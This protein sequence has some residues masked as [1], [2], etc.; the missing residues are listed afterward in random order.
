MCQATETAA[1]PVLKIQ[2]LGKGAVVLH[3]PWQFHLGDEPSF[4]APD[5]DDATGNDGWEQISADAPWGKQGHWNDSGY[6]WYRI[7]LDITPAS[8]VAPDWSML[9]PQ[10]FDIYSIYWNGRLIVT[11][12]TF[13]PY[14]E[15]TWV[16]NPQTFSLGPLGNGVLAV[17]V[18][19][20]PPGSTDSGFTGGF[21][22][23]P[24]LGGPGAIAT[25]AA[26]YKYVWLR[27]QLFTFATISLQA[28]LMLLALIAWW[29]DRSQHLLLFTACFCFGGIATFADTRL[30]L[31]FNQLLG[32]GIL[33]P[34]YAVRDIGLMYLV[35]WLLDLQRIPSLARWTRV[36]AIANAIFMLADGAV[37]VMDWSNPRLTLFCQWAD[38]LLTVLYSLT[39][40]WPVVLVLFAI[41][42]RLDTPRWM[43]AVFACLA[44]LSFLVP[45]TLQQGSR[46]THWNLGGTLMRPLFT[47]MGNEF[48]AYTLANF[49]LLISIFYAVFAYSR[50]VL[51]RK[52]TIE[53]ELRSAKELMQVLIPEALPSLKGFAL[54]S[55]Y[56]PAAEVGGDFFQILP[57]EDGSSVVAIGDVSG[58]GLRAA[59][60][61]SLIVGAL[62]TLVE[63]DPAPAAILAGLNRRLH[64]RLQGG[65][66]TCLILRL[67]AEGRCALANAGHPAPFL[68]GH[69]VTLGGSL[70]LGISEDTSWEESRL[71]LQV[72]DHLV[73]YT[74]GLL[75]ARNERGEIFSFDRLAA[76]LAERLSAEQ[77]LAA[78]K[79]FGQEDDITVLTLSRLAVGEKAT[80]ELIAPVL[81]QA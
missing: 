2:D 31:G 41:R 74:D 64:N 20:F 23:A 69:E 72:Q 36:F 5:L 63:T 44:Q 26:A 29:R 39:E 76:L 52:Q 1:P 66:A 81:V 70:P 15:Y 59:M 45:V 25:K 65:F 19:K 62:R 71:Q 50:K 67:D 30:P 6:G 27:G 14:A 56:Q 57:V 51:I 12:G 28:L 13:P 80:S 18:Y 61:V 49:G 24:I 38:G 17:R 68:N 3:G 37:C 77:A 46:F 55:A 48:D 7:H 58:K 8:G 73:L 34:A 21:A 60:A 78:A 33:L 43:V 16:D 40:F 79:A 35:L 10:V 11:H 9:V 22:A 47:L 75:E 42:H 4:A 53:Q 54:T 32:L